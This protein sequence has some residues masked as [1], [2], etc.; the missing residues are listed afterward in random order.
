L[1]TISGWIFEVYA[2]AEGLSVWIIDT[3]SG[4]HH[5]HDTFSPSFFVYGP[6]PDLHAVCVMLTTA[7]LPVH[8]RRAERHDLF[9][10]R[11]LVVLEVQVTCPLLFASIFKRV[12]TF[13]PDLTFYNADLTP[14]QF[15]Y[16]EKNLFPLAYCAVQVNAAGHI[17]EI[18]LKD[19]RWALDYPLPPLKIM[20]LQL[21]GETQDPNHGFRGEIEI[22]VEG[23]VSVLDANDPREMLISLG[24]LLRQH[25]PDLLIS[26]YGD[27]FILPKLLEMSDRYRIPIPLNRDLKQVPLSKRAYSYSSYGRIV[28]RSASQILFGRW[29]IDL[30][31]SFRMGDY[32][33]DGIFELSR[34]TGLSVQ[35]TARTSTGTG[36]SAMEAATAYHRKIL[37]PFQKREPED[38]KSAGELIVA[39][40]GGLT[41][42]PLVGLHEDVA[43]IDFA[44]MYPFIMAKFNISP[45]TVNCP[46]CQNQVV[47]EIGY[48]ICAKHKGLIPETLEPLV[49]KRLRYK[50]GAKDLTDDVRRKIY[51]ER[52]QALKGILV[53]CFGYT[54]YK[55]ARFGK[56]EAH[57]AINAYSRDIL[58]QTKEIVEAHGFEVLHLLIDSLW[59][60]K[61]GTQD[62]EYPPLIAEITERTGLPIALEGVYH[63][64]AFLPVRENKNLGV[65][66]RY[67]GVFQDGEI[68]TRGIELRRGDTAPWIKAVQQQAIDI[69]A[70][71]HTRRE[72]CAQVPQVIE[73]L[74]TQ[75]ELLR[76]RQVDYRD[77]VLTYRLTREPQAYQ[78]QTLN[79]IVARQ[80]TDA[81]VKLHAGESVQYIIT[82]AQ[83]RQPNDRARAIELF[84]T[85]QGYDVDQY[86]ELL[87]RAMATILQPA[88]LDQAQIKQQVMWELCQPTAR[89]IPLDWFR[90]STTV[91]PRC[92]R[93]STLIDARMEGDLLIGED[94]HTM[95][96]LRKRAG[97]A[98]LH[99]TTARVVRVVWQ[100]QIA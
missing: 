88:G 64:V 73:L 97:R 18:E 81:G 28:Y 85:D 3:T 84:K 33:L 66:N 7:R 75:L 58:I 62:A 37:I 34:L 39:D 55:N 59:I 61:K 60:K 46:C 13:K 77:L 87:L 45:E 49:T 19:S 89:Q 79:A 98:R 20:S 53:T 21:T 26:R 52:A 72:F 31:N 40:K 8:L 94:D 51:R 11:D 1:K 76:A 91:V 22:Q 17:L 27:S 56:I 68:K 93:E 74:R 71:A 83:A 29:H 16:F 30:Q 82:N 65:P 12:Q 38:F 23:R 70:L 50:L 78:H 24:S 15:Y 63:W 90:G 41:Y 80:L 44:S 54:G 5:L 86:T 4:K 6:Q 35:K 95:N 48:S 92:S 9:L 100:N 25:D 36:I 32:W 2:D 67:F 57:E 42:R 99:E 69:L 96:V 47:P 10:R 43:E 14:A